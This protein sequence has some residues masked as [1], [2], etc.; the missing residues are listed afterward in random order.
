MKNLY[1]NLNINKSFNFYFL[2]IVLLFGVIMCSYAQVR[3]PFQQRTSAVSPERKI[4]N[5]K[6]DYTMIG[7]TN[8]T[9][10]NYG[11]ETS[12]ANTMRYVDV[13]T[14]AS[15]WN[16]SSSTLSFASENGSIPECSNII[17]AGLYWT[18][19]ASD[20]ANSPD[21]FDYTRTVNVNLPI[22]Q[23]YNVGHDDAITNTTYDMVVTRGGQTNT[24]FQFTLFLMELQLMYLV[25]PITLEP[26]E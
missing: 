10:V 26:I 11:D 14:D 17:Y 1:L 24:D 2:Q 19:R 7:N 16:S 8:L 4:Y 25:I 21:I 6:G 23:N 3:V 9:L 5:I 22:N 18:G 20:G 15:T 12:N 13:D